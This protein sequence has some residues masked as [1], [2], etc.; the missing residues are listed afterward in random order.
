MNTVEKRIEGRLFEQHDGFF[1]GHYFAKLLIQKQRVCINEAEYQL[2]KVS[3]RRPVLICLRA[4]ARE[5]P[6]SNLEGLCNGIDDFDDM[7]ITTKQTCV[8]F[9]PFFAHSNTRKNVQIDN[10]DE[11]EKQIR[12]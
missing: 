7:T 5:V 11:N 1:D 4:L 10:I 6:G 2:Q 3:S 8:C 12:P 9:K